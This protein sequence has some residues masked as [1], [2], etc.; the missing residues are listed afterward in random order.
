MGSIN[1]RI[2]VQ[3]SLVKKTIICPKTKEKR[4]GG[5]AQVV[6]SLPSKSQNLPSNPSTNNKITVILILKQLLFV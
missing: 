1:R 4:D 5:M 2:I 6:E 3:T